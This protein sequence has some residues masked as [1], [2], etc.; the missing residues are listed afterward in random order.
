MKLEQQVCS[1]ELSK[2]LCLLGIQQSGSYFAWDISTKTGRKELVPLFSH[3][4]NFHLRS[5][6]SAI[7]SYAAFTVA[8]LGQ[9]LP[10][11]LDHSNEHEKAAGI[12]PLHQLHRLVTEYQDTRFLL[13]VI[14]HPGRA[15][16]QL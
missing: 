10:R 5:P 4:G 16:H 15:S 11:R 2:K 12:H 14:R 9:M 7:V 1:P 13:Y 8:E 3:R 6:R